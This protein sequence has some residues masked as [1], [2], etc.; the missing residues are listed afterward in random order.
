MQTALARLTFKGNKVRNNFAVNL[1]RLLRE[2]EFTQR[3]FA[4]KIGVLEANISRWCTAVSF[5]EDKTIDRIA[6]LLKVSYE[7]LVR[8]PRKP[9]E[10]QLILELAK[11]AGYELKLS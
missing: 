10:R 3:D 4:A 9:P 1:K 11:K 5:P 6:A 8:D 2:R 7:E